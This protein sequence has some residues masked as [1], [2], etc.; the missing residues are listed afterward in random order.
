MKVALSRI[1]V[2]GRRMRKTTIHNHAWDI[3]AAYMDFLVWDFLGVNNSASALG[4]GR[5]EGE[6]ESRARA[7]F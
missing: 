6:R 5:G 7:G 4:A 2:G 3:F 1:I